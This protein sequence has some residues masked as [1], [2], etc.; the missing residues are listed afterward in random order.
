MG[1]SKEEF[2]Q[3]KDVVFEDNRRTVGAGS[4]CAIQ[5]CVMSLL[6]S[7]RASAYNACRLVFIFH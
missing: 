4:M 1:V 5:F 3:V 6:M 2:N 7:L